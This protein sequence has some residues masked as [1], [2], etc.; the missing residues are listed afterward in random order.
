MVA[1]VH[2]AMGDDGVLNVVG[3]TVAI[4]LLLGLGKW[5]DVV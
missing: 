3:D 2:T 4:V 5:S 1:V